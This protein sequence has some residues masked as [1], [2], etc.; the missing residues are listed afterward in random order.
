M[1]S[2]IVSDQ[3]ELT[4]LGDSTDGAPSSAKTY[5]RKVTEQRAVLHQRILEEYWRRRVNDD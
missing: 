4:L 3:G 2:D 5:K 1:L